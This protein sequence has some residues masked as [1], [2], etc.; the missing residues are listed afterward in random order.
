[1][2]SKRF[3]T[4]E[5]AKLGTPSVSLNN[6]NTS[7]N[8]SK[9]NSPP[10]AAIGLTLLTGFNKDFKASNAWSLRPGF[11]SSKRNLVKTFNN[12]M[13][14]DR[15]TFLTLENLTTVEL[16]LILIHRIL[17]CPI[18]WV[19]P[20][21]DQHVMIDNSNDNLSPQ[22]SYVHRGVMKNEV[23]G[24]EKS[25]L[26]QTFEELGLMLRLKI[27]SHQHELMEKP[28]PVSL[29]PCEHHV[30]EELQDVRLLDE[31]LNVFVLQGDNF[32]E[33]GIVFEELSMVGFE[34]RIVWVILQ[35]P[36]YAHDALVF[37]YQV[38]HQPFVEQY[39]SLDYIA[40]QM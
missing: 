10:P 14:L 28:D 21:D 24:L 6:W 29:L 15:V 5:Y 36:H 30:F 32:F 17:R 26:D 40:Q 37:Q 27:L 12:V 23:D 4:V 38:K 22:H 3:K 1:M 33:L 25:L 13:S 7:S 16:F 2:I 9:S 35:D 34:F 19:D 18:F 20:V 8:K 31:I 11:E 39:Q